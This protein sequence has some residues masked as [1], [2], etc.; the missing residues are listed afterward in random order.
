M[1]C[2]LELDLAVPRALGPVYMFCAF[3]LI[4]YG[5]E[6]AKSSFHC[7]LGPAFRGTEGVRSSFHVLRS[8]THFWR[9]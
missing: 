8:L 9:Y 4:F 3:I 7:A 6:G 2:A 5:T 1:F